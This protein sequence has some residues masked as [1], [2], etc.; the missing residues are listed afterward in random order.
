VRRT[1]GTRIPSLGELGGLKGLRM[2]LIGDGMH[3]R[4][5]LF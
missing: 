5:Y 2:L 3:I 4:T 1:F